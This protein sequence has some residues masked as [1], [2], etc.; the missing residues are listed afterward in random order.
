MQKQLVSTEYNTAQ[1]LHGWHLCCR[2]LDHYTDNN[3]FIKREVAMF[4]QTGSTA[5]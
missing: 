5:D 1:L 2:S 4:K 3:E